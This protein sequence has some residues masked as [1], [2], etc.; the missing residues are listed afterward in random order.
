M[1]TDKFYDVSNLINLYKKGT[2]PIG[3]VDQIR[4]MYQG[5]NDGLLPPKVKRSVGRPKKQRFYFIF[6]EKKNNCLLQ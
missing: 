4:N 6:R 2:L 5:G 3:S 1:Y